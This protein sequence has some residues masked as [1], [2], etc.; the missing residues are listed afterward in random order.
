M[1]NKAKTFQDHFGEQNLEKIR[2][3]LESLFTSPAG[4]VMIILPPD[5]D[6]PRPKIVDGYFNVH[7]NC[8]RGMV[9]TSLKDSV[10]QGLL[11]EGLPTKFYIGNNKNHNQ[12]IKKRGKACLTGA[13]TH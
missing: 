8:V 5:K 10:K 7:A 9:D 1:S 6:N 12:S 2:K 13:K 4:A 3:V 11:I